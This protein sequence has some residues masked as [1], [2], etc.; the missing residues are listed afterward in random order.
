[1]FTK[2]YESS[3]CPS[4][5]E[6]DVMYAEELAR[7]LMEDDQ[8]VNFSWLAI[9]ADMETNNSFG[10]L[11]DFVKR[12]VLPPVQCCVKLKTDVNY[13]ICDRAQEYWPRDGPKNIRT[14]GDSNNCPRAIAH[15]FLGDQ[16]RHLE[17]RVDITLT[18]I[19]EEES[20]LLIKF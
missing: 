8:N 7:P 17:V 10:T 19:L 1:M 11:S 6:E 20:F 9:L 16:N 12:T 3:E 4:S 13:V 18:A 15:V 5:D 2:E 14:I